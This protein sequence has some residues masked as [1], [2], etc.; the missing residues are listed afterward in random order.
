MTWVSR[1]FLTVGIPD[2]LQPPRMSRRVEALGRP[3]RSCRCSSA[4]ANELLCLTIPVDGSSGM[5]RAS[6][7]SP[8]GTTTRDRAVHRGR[9][10]PAQRTRDAR[11]EP[12]RLRCEQPHD[13]G[14]SD[15]AQRRGNSE[16]SNRRESNGL[17]GPVHRWDAR[18]RRADRPGVEDPR[19]THL[20]CPG[21]R[22][23][24]ARRPTPRLRSNEAS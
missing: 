7:T 3:S 9:H 23:S 5:P 18:S 20:P 2:C 17:A 15:R 10:G 4:E 21:L 19:C 11:L 1:S 16:I 12:V 22:R 6:S 14:G 13:L 24:F 8:R